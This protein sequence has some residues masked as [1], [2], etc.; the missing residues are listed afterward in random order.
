VSDTALGDW[1]VNRIVVDRQPLLMLVSSKSRLSILTPARD[2]KTL[3]QRLAGIVGDRLRRLPVDPRLVA[4]E[5]NVIDQ[6]TVGR[7]LDR[8]V[9]G[10]LVDFAKALPYYLPVNDW[11]ASTL[12]AAEDEL[13][14]TPCLASRPFDEVIFPERAAVRLLETMWPVSRT[15]H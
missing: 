9:T 3:P 5:L 14:E 15:R 6:V 8:S 4:S 10:Q 7:T 1:Y 11:D 13:A 2:V 12:R